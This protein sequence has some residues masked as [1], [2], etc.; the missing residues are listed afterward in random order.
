MVTDNN[1]PNL[2]SDA[3]IELAQILCDQNDFEQIL[4]LITQK[5]AQ[6]LDAK[7]VL[8][9]MINPRTHQT[10]KTVFTE[11]EDIAEQKYHALHTSISGWVIKNNLPLISSNIKSDNRFRSS[12]FKDLPAES[13]LCVPL[14]CENI[15][16]GTLSLLDKKT[17]TV[18]SEADL[19]YLQKLALIISPFLRNVQKIEQYFTVPIPGRT[20]LNKY[21]VFGLLGKSK[22]YVELL[23]AVEAAAHCDV[24]VLLEGESGVGKELIARAI[25]N[26]SERSGNKFIAVDCGAIPEKLIE[27]ELFGH[28]KGAYTGATMT[29][30]GLFSEANNGTLFMD[31]ITNLPLDLQAKLLRVLQEG[32]IRP[33]GSNTTHRV[34]VRVITAASIPL[35]EQVENKKFR[36]D[37]FYRL[38]VYPIH[39]PSLAERQ[40]DIPLLANHFL[41]K[42]SKQQNKKIET[43]HE[44][45]IDLMKYHQWTGNIRELENF[46]ERMV[47]LTVQDRKQIDVSLLPREYSSELKNLK[48]QQVKVQKT[49][50][51]SENLADYEKEL[52]RQALI[53]YDWNQTAA[54]GALGIHES[55]LRYKM[56]KYHL[57]KM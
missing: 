45:V 13:A 2:K 3:L 36:E 31:E 15:V 46:V 50:L 28:V 54:A 47:T 42:F 20:L 10:M 5:T 26:C 57:K 29:R 8:I 33:L 30:A 53:R 24:R 14:M 41:Q 35:R 21:E 27:S 6:L 39:V 9:M 12:V 25:H 38:F 18:F 48:Q 4:R 23:Q 49:K 17:A 19:S 1:N 34:N 55:T 37:L 44:Q 7:M 43:F 16:I 51:L 56:K 11:G 52:M 40:E 32:E 22:K